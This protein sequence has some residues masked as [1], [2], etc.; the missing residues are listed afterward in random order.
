MLRLFSAWNWQWFDLTYWIVKVPIGI[1]IVR[2]EKQ[3]QELQAE[4]RK[5]GETLSEL[6]KEILEDEALSAGDLEYIDQNVLK[7]RIGFWAVAFITFAFWGDIIQLTPDKLL[8]VMAAAA[9]MATGFITG[10]FAMSL[11]SL[12]QRYGLLGIIITYAMFTAFMSCITLVPV[13]F[14][15]VGSIRLLAGGCLVV[16]MAY[17]ATFFY[18]FGDMLNLGLEP[19]Q[20]RYFKKPE[21]MIIG[22]LVEALKTLQE[23]NKALIEELKALRKKQS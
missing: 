10:W 14:Y 4:L 17:V 19:L 12:P 18:D 13:V 8:V 1:L 11:K 23:T 2:K 15:T 6:E 5:K 20:K 9:V 7:H 3:L 21:V 16:A 22:S